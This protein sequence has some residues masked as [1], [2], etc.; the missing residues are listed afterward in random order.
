MSALFS[1]ADGRPIDMEE[2]EDRGAYVTERIA[3]LIEENFDIDISDPD[4]N[5]DVGMY[6]SSAISA[7]IKEAYDKFLDEEELIKE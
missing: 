4:S 2:L 3:E 1:S 5:S 7:A 6:V